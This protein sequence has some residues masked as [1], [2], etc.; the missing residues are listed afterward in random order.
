MSSSVASL[1]TVRSVVLRTFALA[2][3]LAAAMLALMGSGGGPTPGRMERS[4]FR[5]GA[6]YWLLAKDGGVFA[7][8]DAKFF[9]P[10]RNQGQ[11]IAGMAATATGNGYWTVDDDGDVFAYGDAVDFGSRPGPEIDNIT[12]FAARTQ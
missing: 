8:G 3:A 9:G 6:G 12:G 1:G 10:N 4:S 7:F 5:G 11:D 2:L